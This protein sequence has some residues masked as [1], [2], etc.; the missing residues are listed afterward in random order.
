MKK[1]TDPPIP[2]VIPVPFVEGMI[3]VDKVD[4]YPI[5]VVRICSK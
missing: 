4:F 3:M 2:N 1:L 5:N